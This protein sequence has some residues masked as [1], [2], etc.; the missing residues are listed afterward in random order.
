VPW[1]GYTADVNL[2]LI[3]GVNLTISMVFRTEGIITGMPYN[4]SI[5]IRVFDDSDRV[6][7]ATT[8]MADAGTLL[9]SSNSGYFADGIKIMKEAVPAGTKILVYKNLA[10][11]FGYVEPSS[12][13]SALRS[14]TL[15]SSDHGIWGSS[16]LPGGYSGDWTVMVDIVNWYRSGAYYTPAPA[17]LQG[18]SPY[19]FPYNHLGPYS[20]KGLIEISNVPQTGEASAILG[21]ELRGYIKGTVL[22]LNWEENTRTA[23]LATLQIVD[24]SSYQYYWYTWDGWFDG[25]LDPGTYHVTITEWK[26]NEGYAPVSFVLEVTRGQQEASLNFILVESQIPIPEFPTISWSMIFLIVASGFLKFSRRRRS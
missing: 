15:F 9:P 18:E 26:N 19:F 23:S 2:K 20:Q 5:R 10:G 14:A 6:V 17:L 7:A 16:S 25:Y 12:E 1:I 4:V 3:I 24:N 21:L 8:L 13:N 11:M 22:A